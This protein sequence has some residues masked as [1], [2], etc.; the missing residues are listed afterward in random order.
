[1]K[2]IYATTAVVIFVLSFCASLIAP[3][4]AD[5]LG[6]SISGQVFFSTGN[7]NIPSGTI[8]S[9]VN[10]S[11]V[12]DYIS[13]YNMTLNQSGYFQFLSIPYGLYKVYAWSPYYAEG[14]SAGIN[15]S[16]ND[17]YVASVV[18]TAIPY[19]ANITANTQYVLYQSQAD[20]T[21]QVA[22]YWGNPVGSGWPIQL[23]T[24]VGTLNP[25]SAFTDSNGKVTTTIAWVN[26]ATPANI[27]ANSVSINGTTYPLQ[28]EMAPIQMTPSVTP[29]SSANATPSA[30]PS[31]APNA[32]VIALPPT[33]APSATTTTATPTPGFELVA[34][35]VA[36]VIVVA[37]AGRK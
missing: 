6:G 3:A 7:Q 25:A 10:A 22:D 2:T 16:S 15:I 27:T 36:L 30:S 32:T 5:A 19:Y 9:L 21:V 11:N 4:S 13:G 12:S 17:T 37:L 29:I 35:L 18:L 28:A 26:S 33:T 23:N 20:I 31:T 24:T 14:Y 34:A 8:V 1:M